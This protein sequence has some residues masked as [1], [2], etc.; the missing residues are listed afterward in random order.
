MN[1]RG[2]RERDSSMANTCASSCERTIPQ[3]KAWLVGACEVI[4]RPKQ[5]PD[6][7][8]DG[9]ADGRDRELLR[10]GRRARR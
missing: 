4:T 5:T 10:V 3:L 2:T 8:I 6:T 1:Q 9:E 7:P